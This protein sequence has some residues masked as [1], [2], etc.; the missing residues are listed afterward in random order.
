MSETV[1]YR[2]TRKGAIAHAIMEA[3]RC[4]CYA[5]YCQPCDGLD[6]CIDCL[7]LAAAAVLKA[8]RK[9]T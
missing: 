9:W 4:P 7:A 8:L 1:A 2:Q 3:E 6:G 5:A